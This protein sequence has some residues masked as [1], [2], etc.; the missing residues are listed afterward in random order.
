MDKSATAARRRTS[1]LQRKTFMPLSNEER[2]RIALK[3]IHGAL[4]SAAKATRHARDEARQIDLRRLEDRCDAAHEALEFALNAFPGFTSSPEYEEAQRQAEQA[5]RFKAMKKTAA[6]AA[7]KA[8]KAPPSID[9][10][11]VDTAMASAL[12]NASK[13][14]LRTRS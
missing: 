9:Q 12:K 8:K 10:P 14:V 6:K 4:T 11:P 2:I 13:A 5:R 3:H 1:V 7:T